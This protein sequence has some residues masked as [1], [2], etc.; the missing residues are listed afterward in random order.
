MGKRGPKARPF[1]TQV[2]FGRGCWEWTGSRF[3]NGYGR[4]I[5]GR[6]SVGAHRVA[7]ELAIGPL[8]AGQLVMHSCDNKGCV[9]PD[10]LSAG[11]PADNLADM[12]AKGRSLRGERNHWAKLSESTVREIRVAQASG[13]SKAS[14]ARRLDVSE[15]AIR[16]VM[17]G[18]TWGW[19][20]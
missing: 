18:R 10:H 16:S 12:V 2:R 14:L 9:R 3:S 5:V 7:Y 4:T 6:K 19:V 8:L 11:T 17:Q 1:W 15:T 13:E 20:Q